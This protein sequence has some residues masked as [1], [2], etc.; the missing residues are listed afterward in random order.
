MYYMKWR[1]KC[2]GNIAL[3]DAISCKYLFSLGITAMKFAQVQAD[4]SKLSMLG[5]QKDHFI[6]VRIGDLSSDIGNSA[7]LSRGHIVGFIP[8]IVKGLNERKKSGFVNFKNTIHCTA[9]CFF[10]EKIM[11]LSQV[12]Y[13]VVCSDSIS[14]LLFPHIRIIS[15]NYEEQNIT[16]VMQYYLLEHC[17]Y[18]RS[19]GNIVQIDFILKDFPYWPNLNLDYGNGNKW[20]DVSKVLVKLEH[21]DTS[22]VALALIRVTRR[23]I[24]LNLYLLFIIQTEKTIVAY[25]RILNRFHDALEL[26]KIHSQTHAANDIWLKETINNM[27]SHRTLVSIPLLSFPMVKNLDVITKCQYIKSTSNQR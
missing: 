8:I 5:G 11:H 7:T 10:L 20:E 2:V 15:A 6:V 19:P 14:R 1:L 22:V 3:A 4:T 16:P 26:Y 27:D 18:E 12:D 17:K 24:E 23:W 25:E 9:F 13:K 21:E